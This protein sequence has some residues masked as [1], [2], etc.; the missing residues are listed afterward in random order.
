MSLGKYN[1]LCTED[2]LALLD[3]FMTHE[4]YDYIAVDTE[5][6]GLHF[7][8]NVVIGFSLSI[9]SNSG[10]YIPLLNWVP[11]GESKARK[12]K[13]VDYDV[14]HDGN[15]TCIWTGKSYPENVTPQE[16]SPPQFIKDY[17]KKWFM[18]QKLLMHNAPFD[19]LM[20][21]SNFGVNLEDFVFCDT[22]LLKHVID[23]NTPCGLKPTAIQWQNLLN[24]DVSKDANTEQQ[25]MGESV[26]RNGGKFTKKEK[27]IWRADPELLGKY[28]VADTF[29]T[30]GIF[31]VGIRKLANEYDPKHF[32]WFFDDEVMPLCREVIIDMKRKG[33]P[34]DVPYFEELEKETKNKLDALEDS[35]V[36]ELGD[37]LDNFTVGKSLDEAVSQKALVERIIELEDLEYP[38]F[39][40]GK[41]IGKKSLSKAVVKKINDQEPHW[42]WEYILGEGE[43]RYSDER[44]LE[45]KQKLYF[46]KEN[47]RYRFNI[48]SDPHLRWLFCEYFGHDKMKLPQTDSATPDNPIASM[49]AEVLKEFFLKDYEFVKPLLLWKKLS[50][51]HGTYILP[52]LN[53]HNNGYLHMDFLQNGTVSGRFACRGGFNLQTLPKVEELEKCPHCGSRNIV[54]THPIKIIADITCNDCNGVEEGILCPSAIKQGFIAPEGM[55]IVNADYS[56]LEPRCFAFMSG[57]TKLKEIY[58]NDLDMYSKVYCDMEDKKG[59][60]SPKGTASC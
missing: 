38:T 20:I 48:G 36:Q 40:S 19:V 9:N 8:K 4:K 27:H 17:V 58:W 52:I 51:L 35:I 54:I 23:E 53:L 41:N 46:E 24:L 22:A 30:Y 31:D 43:I 28:A 50:K 42:L 34:V 37:I 12:V 10:F 39:Q 21:E 11:K 56:S 3:Q 45:I 57:D 49:K 44:I 60:Y 13:K 5:T 26:I 7:W 15:F 55:D 1:I 25:E 33:V 14:K 2:D 59:E 18:N 16:Y 47:R 6:N 29:L 32:T